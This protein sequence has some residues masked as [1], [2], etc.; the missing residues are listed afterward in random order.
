[1]TSETTDEF[2]VGD[3]GGLGMGGGRG[4]RRE[5]MGGG[6]GGEGRG[7]AEMTVKAGVD[8]TV[9]QWVVVLVDVSP[10]CLLLVVLLSA[11][12]EPAEVGRV[13]RPGLR[14]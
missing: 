10:R 7:V 1:M 2:M 13:R 5:G 3:I 11:V 8:L 6:G 14:H 4:E 12:V 9:I